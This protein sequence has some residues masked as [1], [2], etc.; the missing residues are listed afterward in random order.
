MEQFIIKKMIGKKQ[1]KNKF[2]NNY[3]NYFIYFNYFNM[4]NQLYFL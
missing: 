4:N 1:V 2:F 3:Y